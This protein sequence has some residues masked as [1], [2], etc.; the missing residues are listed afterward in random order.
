MGLNDYFDK[1]FVINLARRTDRWEACQEEL[2]KHNIVAER[3]LG[4]DHPWHGNAG[5]TRA[6]RELLR[7]IANGTWERVLVLED[8]FHVLTYMDLVGGGF[9]DSGPVVKTFV[10]APGRGLHE[11]FDKM[12]VYVPS[13][14]DVLYLGGGYGEDPIARVHKHVIRCG[15]MLTTSSYG[16]TRRFAR[17]W[18]DLTD[19]GCLQAIAE[20]DGPNIYAAE[21]RDTPLGVYP[22][23]ID[24]VFMRYAHDYH[25]YVF[26]PRLMIQGPG[27]SDLTGREE[28]YLQSM[29]DCHH[30]NLV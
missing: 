8:D 11:R 24:S 1:V 23:P 5:C 29:V 3:H 26:Q 15:G 16:I 17:I 30:E 18:S 27:R 10:G 7:K 12:I 13:D 20:S 21:E 6:H 28:S 9:I 4:Y 14:W 25:Y 2:A 19:I 22:G